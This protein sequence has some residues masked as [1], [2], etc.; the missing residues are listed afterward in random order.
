LL[1]TLL[2]LATL[3][4]QES[5]RWSLWLG[6]GLLWGVTGLLNPSILV[7][8]PFLGVWLWFRH[9]RSG[10]NCDVSMATAALVCLACLSIWLVRDFRTFGKF[11]PL[12]SN[13]AL[14]FQLGNSDDT[15]RP[16]SDR[17]LPP[18]NPAEMERFRELGEMT[19]MAE[20][21]QQAKSALRQQPDR[22]VWLT[23]RRILF[24]W[25]GAWGAH[26][27]WDIDDEAGVPNIIVYSLLSLLAFLGLYRSIQ[28]GVSFTIPLAIILFFFPLLYYVTHPDVRYRHPIDPEIVLLAVYGALSIGTGGRDDATESRQDAT[29]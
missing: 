16:A 22:F 11:I 10:M 29:R 19:Y 24:L 5:C 23:L 20:K 12:R 7:T 18:D 2:V 4:L 14:E 28:N 26:P 9:R 27:S 21:Q 17:F 6:Y 8:F 25:T 1:F 13:F 15:S 3:Y